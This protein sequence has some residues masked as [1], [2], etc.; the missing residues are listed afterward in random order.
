MYEVAHP[1]RARGGFRC[2]A[3]ARWHAPAPSYTTSWHATGAFGSETGFGAVRTP[4]APA[5]A[6]FACVFRCKNNEKTDLAPPFWR[7]D[8]QNGESGPQSAAITAPK[9][10]WLPGGSGL[11]HRNPSGCQAGRDCCTETRLPA[12]WDA[13]AAPKPI[14]LPNG[15]RLLHR[16]SPG[17]HQTRRDC[18]EPRPAAVRPPVSSASKLI[19]K[20]GLLPRSHKS[21]PG[22]KPYLAWGFHARGDETEP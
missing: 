21:R 10:V 8:G 2:S 18:A 20:Y 15:M 11:L 9:P 14:C 7:P 5:S 6:E 19:R 16:N 3:G 1:P 13:V 4:S 12:K 22:I 17:C